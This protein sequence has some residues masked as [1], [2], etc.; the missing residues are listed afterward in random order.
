ML[1][2][3]DEEWKPIR[4]HFPEENLPDGRHGR[5]PV[6]AREV[7]EGA[8]RILNSSVQWRRLPQGY[9][10]YQTVLRRLQ[11]WCEKQAL[12]EV[13]PELAKT[14]R[15]EGEIDERECVIDAAFCSAR[16]G[17][18]DIGKT[19]RGKGVKILAIVDRHG[20]PLSVS[21]HAANHHEVTLVQWSF[22]F[23]MLEAKPEKPIGDR[24][25]D[26]DS[27]GA[28]PKKEGVEM[29]APH[30]SDR[31]LKAEDGRRLRRYE[32]CW[33]VK[34]FFAWI[35]WTRRLLIGG[36]YYAANF[37]GFV[38]LASITMLVKRI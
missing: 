31:T 25:Y 12:R 32:R 35:Q 28:K 36:G 29:I 4:E 14:L 17:G 15:H 20:P 21:T 24:A 10:N 2:L 34:R 23:Y 5:K 9:P 33:L 7:L 18:K 1:R 26:R 38:Q 22:N 6:S 3:S 11:Q 16:G 37:L 19:E 27:L 8:L 13:L 30:R